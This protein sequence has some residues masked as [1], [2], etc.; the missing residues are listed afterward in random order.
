M[1]LEEFHMWQQFDAE[2]PMGD[3]RS[4]LHSALVCQAVTNMSGRT[5]KKPVS[6]DKFVPFQPRQEEEVS[7]FEHFRRMQKGA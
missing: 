6:L 1:S 7:P 5:V 4:D 2:S 3:L